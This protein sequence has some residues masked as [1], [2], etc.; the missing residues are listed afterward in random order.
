MVLNTF[1]SEIFPLLSTE[2]ITLILQQIHQ[3][4]PIG[5]EQVRASSTYKH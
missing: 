2:R 3:I 1:K 4:L 5:L